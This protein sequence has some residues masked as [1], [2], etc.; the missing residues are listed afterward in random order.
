[1]SVSWPAATSAFMRQGGFVNDWGDPIIMPHGQHVELY[2]KWRFES[3]TALTGHA[4][5]VN[6]GT[7]ELH[8][9][10]IMGGAFADR[11]LTLTEADLN[12]VYTGI[13]FT[14]SERP[15]MFNGVKEGGTDE[16]SHSAHPIRN[17]GDDL[18][19]GVVDSA[20]VTH[21]GLGSSTGVQ[22]LFIHT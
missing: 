21:P 7:C 3:A 4:A 15:V 20:N 2:G 5:A 12:R 8:G 1:M 16:I 22:I 18:F 9:K 17:A 19:T 14:G 6:S 13:D 10:L 11:G